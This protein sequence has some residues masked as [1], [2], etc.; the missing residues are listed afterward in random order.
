MTI[1]S[2]S[3]AVATRRAWPTLERR[4]PAKSP[5]EA[6]LGERVT[7]AF[8]APQIEKLREHVARSIPQLPDSN[9]DRFLGSLMDSAAIVSAYFRP[10]RVM[11]STAARQP[12]MQ[13]VLPFDFALEAARKAA[14]AQIL[15]PQERPVAWLAAFTY[16]VAHFYAAD[17]A[18][19]PD[20]FTELP[21]QQRLSSLRHSLVEDALRAM[22]RR[23]G[24]LAQTLAAA[25]GFEP[26]EVCE[27]QQVARLVSAV[28]LATMRIEQLWRRWAMHESTS[29]LTL[30]TMLG[31]WSTEAEAKFWEELVIWCESQQLFIGGSLEAAVVYA[32][33]AGRLRG[34]LRIL[35]NLLRSR[36][37][38]ESFSLEL[39]DLHW[40]AAPRMRLAAIEAVSSAQQFLFERAL[41]TTQAFAGITISAAV[42]PHAQVSADGKRLDV[43]L[44]RQQL[45]VSLERL[46]GQTEPVFDMFR[47]GIRAGEFHRLIAET[48]Y[49]HWKP[50]E[51]VG[52]LW[53]GDWTAESGPWRIHVH[54]IPGAIAPAPAHSDVMRRLTYV[55]AYE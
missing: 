28:R 47:T 6:L 55:L 54:A 45:V 41:D 48:A 51:P 2:A 20:A 26:S 24:V 4:A 30:R 1:P 32:L 22:G 40:L 13:L 27:A 35:R 7:G 29:V 43:T 19:G 21:H 9:L 23:H 16:P 46:D 36:I 37:D 11:A 8:T 42:R 38:G 18:R 3:T 5:V 14:S 15:L 53:S 44:P 49:L 10:T 31:G 25:L 12:L 52:D 39:S 50:V 33:N 17:T 34:Q